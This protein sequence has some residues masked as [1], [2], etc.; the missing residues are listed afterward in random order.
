MM[1]I[2]ILCLKLSVNLTK[3]GPSRFNR[4]IPNAPYIE[5]F[6]AYFMLC[7]ANKE[8]GVPRPQRS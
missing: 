6:S 7:Y 3:K 5:F 2:F 1:H 4:I 8:T